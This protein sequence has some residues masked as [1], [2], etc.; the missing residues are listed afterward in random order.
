MSLPQWN[1]TPQVS[2]VFL[3]LVNNDTSVPAI[4]TTLKGCLIGRK[5]WSDGAGTSGEKETFNVTSPDS[6]AHSKGST[7]VPHQRGLCY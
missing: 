5:R 7:Q 3:S 4:G 6:L 1:L 2:E